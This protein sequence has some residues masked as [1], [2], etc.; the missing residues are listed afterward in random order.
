M[1]RILLTAGLI[2]VAA[3]VVL[4]SVRS[5]PVPAP[6]KTEGDKDKPA[7]ERS[8]DEAAIRANV[9]KFM[10]AYN[11]GD[12]KAIAALFTPD[13]VIINKDGDESRGQ[14]AIAATFKEILAETPKKQLEVFVESIRFVDANVAVETGT[15]KETSAANEPPEIDRYTVLHVKRDGKWFMALARDEEGPPPSGY[16]RL[17]PLAWLVG[18]WIDDGGSSV[19]IS[20]CRWSEDRSFLLQ[21]FKLKISG[22]DAMNVSQRIGWDPHRKCIRSWTFDSEGGFGES[23][24]TRDGDTWIIKATGV[25]PDGTAASATNV[26]KQ[27]GGNGYL[28]QSRDR[29]LGDETQDDVEVKVVRKPPTPEK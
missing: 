6:Q 7:P 4:Q 27:A 13:G 18:D 15:T 19:V 2:L 12:A 5:G 23:L 21:E 11:A 22:K 1:R 25:R 17:K 10:K 14:E 29:I 24:W 26:L 8:A 3:A 9:E 20:S 28:W 16:E